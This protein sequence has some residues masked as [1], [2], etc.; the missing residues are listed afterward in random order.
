[1]A[2]GQAA[3]ALSYGES[4]GDRKGSS[5]FMRLPSGDPARVGSSL[6]RQ[7][8]SGRTSSLRFWTVQVVVSMLIR[9]LQFFYSNLIFG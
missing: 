9:V 3:L 7:Q 5:G 2:V 4:Q 8:W 6:G 1:M